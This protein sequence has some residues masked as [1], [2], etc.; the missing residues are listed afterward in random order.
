LLKIKKV[1]KQKAQEKPNKKDK[2]TWPD[3]N[4]RAL[5]YL[6]MGVFHMAW[7]Q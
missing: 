5:L 3:L 1:S 4:I 6:K 2:L 7:I